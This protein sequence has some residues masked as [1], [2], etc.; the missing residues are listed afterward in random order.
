MQVPAPTPVPAQSPSGPSSQQYGKRKGTEGANGASGSVSKF[1]SSKKMKVNK[2]TGD[3]NVSAK[4]KTSSKE[5]SSKSFSDVTPD[6][7]GTRRSRNHVQ[8]K[9]EGPD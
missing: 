6:N 8:S 9:E 7:Q 5:Q 1:S 4:E 3:P 2:E